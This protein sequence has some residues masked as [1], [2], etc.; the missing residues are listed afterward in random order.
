MKWIF[1]WVRHLTGALV[2]GS[3]ALFAAPSVPVYVPEAPPLT[4]LNDGDRHGIAGDLA[5]KAMDMA[6]YSATFLS[7]PWPR[8]QRDVANG[9]NLLI[10]PLTRT[11][12]RENSFTWI[13]P[14]LTMDRT[15][16]SLDRRVDSFDEA[17]K[18]FKLIAVGIGSAQE[19][20]LR[21]EGFPASQIY[22]LK[23]GDNPAQM[24]VK[25]RVDA[26]FNGVPE[27][28]YIWKQISDRPLVMSRVLM[29]ANLYLACSKECDSQMVESL[30]KA[31]DTLQSDG[32][33][34]R[35]EASYLKGL[36]AW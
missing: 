18:A 36:P 1:C 12:S 27:T 17:R 31:L 14:L 20:R 6:G 3:S 32:T 26:W 16:F 23:I 34:A 8:A 9:K 5:L 4:M 28:R 13:A 19:T 35:I 21:E 33:A 29:T 10:A 7:P 24:L 15:F 11:Q 22:P 30:R 25:G 2:M